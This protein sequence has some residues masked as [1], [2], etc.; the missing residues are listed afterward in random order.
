MALFNRNS[1][2]QQTRYRVDDNTHRDVFDQI[3][4]H[5]KEVKNNAKTSSKGMMVAIV[6]GT[7]IGWLL[8]VGGF[9]Y[10]KEMMGSL[11]AVGGDPTHKTQFVQPTFGEAFATGLS[12]TGPYA[13]YVY[14]LLLVAIVGVYLY[15]SQMKEADD[16][17]KNASHLNTYTN[18]GRLIQPEELINKFDLFPDAG[19]HSSV[20]AT[21]ILSHMM[22]D[23]SGVG[24][25]EFPQR[26]EKT[27]YDE[28]DENGYRAILH[29]AGEEKLDENGDTLMKKVPVFD[30]KFS[31]K[32]FDSSLTPI[33]PEKRIIYSPNKL[34]YNPKDDILGKDPSRTAADFNVSSSKKNINISIWI[35]NYPYLMIR[36]AIKAK[37][38]KLK[39]QLIQLSKF[40]FKFE[41][42]R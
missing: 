37:R 28:P 39:I 10:L 24:T 41:E 5:R 4:L 11:A 25:K 40:V 3:D 17:T 2:V 7:T 22:L 8:V 31:H 18:D 13:L 38:L 1:D 6:I 21:A 34:L 33:D 14:G 19:A 12:P 32:L 20:E 15:V 29:Y 23:N 16:K 9:F 27:V 26:Y 35:N 30:G 42:L 36:D